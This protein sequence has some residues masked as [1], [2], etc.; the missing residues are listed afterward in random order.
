MSLKKL[1]A[2]FLSTLSIL[3]YGYDT[4]VP[5]LAL[6]VDNTNIVIMEIK[7][8]TVVI[9]LYPDKAPMHV[10]RIKDL[11]GEKFYDG[12]KFH[13]VIEG[14]MVQTG[15][16]K[17]NGTGKSNKPDL[18][19]EFNDINHVR[20]V[21]SMARSAD[22]NSANSQFFIMLGDAKYLDGSYTAFGRVISGMEAIDKIK[23]GEE[24]NNG[25][26]INPDNIITMY[27]SG[28]NVSNIKFD[29]GKNDGYDNE[30]I[31][32]AQPNPIP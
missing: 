16:P 26:V 10:K 3:F 14:F 31:K 7:Y 1:L 28:K 27:I 8:G 17:G 11:V 4:S 25:T 24:I 32:A 30:G 12:L 15:D 13:R 22:I 20:G 29:V 23:K 9:E 2:K 19:A 6:E 5:A 18:K 21:V